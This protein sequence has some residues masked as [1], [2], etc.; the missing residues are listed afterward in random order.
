MF[1]TMID[2]QPGSSVLDVGSE[3]GSHIAAV[4]DD[5]SDLRVSIADI[6][7]DVVRRG[8]ERFGFTPVTLGEDGILP[9]PDGHFDVVFCSSTIEHATVDKDRLRGFRSTRE[10][11]DAALARQ[12]Q[13]ATEIRRV[14]KQY[15]VQTPYR[16]FPIESHTWFP[17][18]I[19]LM[20]RWLQIR[21]IDLLNRFWVKKTQPD[22]HLLTKREMQSL[23]PDALVVFE[24]L[25]GLPKSLIAVRA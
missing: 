15:F 4:L 6:D 19:V 13:L 25:A 18:V 16:Y 5:A 12:A 17:A 7:G 3:D 21:W 1:R 14:G 9:F 20:P 2:L 11:R 10:F 22:F 24:R 23:F 8:Q